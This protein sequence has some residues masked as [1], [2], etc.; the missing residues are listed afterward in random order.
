RPSASRTRQP[1]PETRKRGV[2]PTEPKARTGLLTP[3]GI[4]RRARSKSSRERGAS[5]ALLLGRPVVA[6]VALIVALHLAVGVARGRRRGGRRL[7]ALTG[8]A[9]PLADVALRQA[10]DRDDL[11]VR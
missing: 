11:L 5:T 7:G 10:R 6:P 2:S 3:P 9:V 4:T 8:P 1:S